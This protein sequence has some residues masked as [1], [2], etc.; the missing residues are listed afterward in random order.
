MLNRYYVAS[1][2]AELIKN[3]GIPPDNYVLAADLRHRAEVEPQ[4]GMARERI[5]SLEQE[6]ASIMLPP[7]AIDPVQ[8]EIRAALSLLTPKKAVGYNKVR[9]GRDFDG[10]YIMVDQLDGAPVCYSIGVGFD[11]SWDLEMAF[12]GCQVYQYDPT[13]DRPDCEHPNVHIH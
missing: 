3:F 8:R 5:Q 9:V 4:L 1:E 13:V 2:H 7:D 11:A 6:I 10:G 12:R